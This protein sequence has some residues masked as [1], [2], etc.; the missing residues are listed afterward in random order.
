[1]GPYHRDVVSLNNCRING[2]GTTKIILEIVAD[3]AVDKWN[4]LGG[5]A[6]GNSYRISD[7]TAKDVTLVN[8]SENVEKTYIGGI[9]G[10]MNKENF[11]SSRTYFTPANTSGLDNCAVIGLRYDVADHTD[12]A[13]DIG[14]LYQ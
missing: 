7:C 2:H 1:M 4:A 5:I 9:C 8:L 13:E 11:W 3:S 12:I 6:G 14:F 10:I